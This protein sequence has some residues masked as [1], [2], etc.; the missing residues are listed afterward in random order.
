MFGGAILKRNGQP[1]L[2]AWQSYDAIAAAYD[3]VWA[4]RFRSAAQQLVALANPAP[5]A[6]I[7]DLGTGTGIVQRA[8]TKREPHVRLVVGCD[9]S[10]G[11]LSRAK[12]SGRRLAWAGADIAALPFAAETF[13]L[14]ASAFVLSHVPDYET[15]LREALRVSKPGGT[16][17]L[18]NWA[19]GSDDCGALWS[20]VLDRWIA[21]DD[22]VRAKQ[23]LTPWEEHLGDPERFAGVVQSAGFVGVK[24]E[25]V[26]VEI[27]ASVDAFLADR[28]LGGQGRFARHT[29]GAAAWSRF[30]A[31]AREE[32]LARFGNHVTYTRGVLVAVASKP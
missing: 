10:L 24:V 4:A 11:M 27:S 30:Q 14:V 19:A 32:F 28:E 31:A 6:V 9:R 3:D 18:A 25:A 26:Q 8:I 21:R 12:R 23:E 13:D 29:L 15:A 20:E 17:A 2:S 22:V 1:L 16:L 7:L 5:D